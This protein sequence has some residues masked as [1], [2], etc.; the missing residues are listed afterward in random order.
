MSTG[1]TNGEGATASGMGAESMGAKTG[2]GGTK[3]TGMGTAGKDPG[4]G[5]ESPGTGTGTGLCMTDM[6]CPDFGAPCDM[7]P[8]GSDACNKTFLQ[9]RHVR[10]R[11]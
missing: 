9:R 5:G 6:D 2:T 3:G 10:E 1:G 11:R 4:A 7:S 8:D